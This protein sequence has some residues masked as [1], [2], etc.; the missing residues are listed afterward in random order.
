MGERFPARGDMATG[1][2]DINIALH[3]QEI[4]TA[5]RTNLEALVILPLLSR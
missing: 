2:K 3:L 5:K 4:S 1:A